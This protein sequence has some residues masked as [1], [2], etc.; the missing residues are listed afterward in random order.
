VHFY[1]FNIKSYHAE[2]AHLTELEDLAYRRLLDFYYDTQQPIPNNIP[3]LTRRLRLGSEFIESV[4]QEFFLL[5]EDGWHNE[6]CDEKIAKY[7]AF[8]ERQKT[9]GSKGGR[10]KDASAKP[11]KPKPLP[12]RSTGLQPLPTKPLPTTQVIEDA[13]ASLST[14]GKKRPVLD[15]IP[16]QKIV[17]L[18]HEILP[19]NPRVADL[20]DKRKSHIGARWRSGRLPDLESWRSYFVRC[21]ES[22]FLTG[23]CEP[24]GGR[25]KRFKADI[26]WLINENNIIKVAEGKYDNG[27]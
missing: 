27:T 14:P 10:G 8:I 26:D 22:N 3:L 2:T 4:L 12:K 5:Q 13:D 20:T 25:N 16:Y 7:C 19:A 24:S 23:Q 9:N 6:H 21:S 17:D 18:Y 1:E 11:N 15:G